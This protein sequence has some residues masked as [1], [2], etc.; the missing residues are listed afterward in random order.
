MYTVVPGPARR[1]RPSISKQASPAIARKT[2]SSRVWTC[3]GGLK[4]SGI[5]IRNT[6]RAPPDASLGTSDSKRLSP[7]QRYIARR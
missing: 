2:S 7:Y 6:D 3:R 5:V 4:P 1:R